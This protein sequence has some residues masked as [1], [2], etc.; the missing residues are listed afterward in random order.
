MMMIN[1]M[2]TQPYGEG[3]QYNRSPVTQLLSTTYVE[4]NMRVPY[5]VLIGQGRLFIAMWPKVIQKLNCIWPKKKICCYLYV[6]KQLN[7][8]K[9]N[10]RL[11]VLWSLP[12]RVSVLW[13]MFSARWTS[14]RF[15]PI[16]KLK[17]SESAKP[18]ASKSISPKHYFGQLRDPLH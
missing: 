11:A 1:A 15:L 4:L 6:V 7:S 18:E 8:I 16:V 13:S 17:N 3:S 5:S 12:V 2:N 10:W 14:K 9:F